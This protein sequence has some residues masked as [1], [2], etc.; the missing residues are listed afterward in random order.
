MSLAVLQLGCLRSALALLR[1]FAIADSLVSFTVEGAGCCYGQLQ[2]RYLVWM[3]T[4]WFSSSS[5]L[6]A[7]PIFKE[8]RIIEFI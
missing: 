7:G 1:P 3:E 2:R 6:S 4:S 8:F 5:L